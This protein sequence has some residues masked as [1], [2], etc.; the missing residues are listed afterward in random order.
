MADDRCPEVIREG[1]KSRLHRTR[2]PA[3]AG[4][5]DVNVGGRKVPQKT[6]RP[7]QAEQG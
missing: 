2:C 6:N 4:D 1:G 5:A 3:Q 7:A